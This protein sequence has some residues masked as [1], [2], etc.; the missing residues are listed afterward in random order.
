MMTVLDYDDIILMLNT[1]YVF[2][3]TKQQKTVISHII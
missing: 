2:C 3:I 1:N